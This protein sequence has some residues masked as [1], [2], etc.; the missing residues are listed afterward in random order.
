M[1]RLQIQ[2]LKDEIYMDINQE[3]VKYY[4]LNQKMNGGS[5]NYT[6]GFKKMSSKMCGTDEDY[7]FIATQDWY[8]SM[9]NRRLME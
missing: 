8:Y 4:D 9:L 1:E 2:M 6:I 7:K 3:Q 5:E